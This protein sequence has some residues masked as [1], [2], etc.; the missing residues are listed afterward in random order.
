VETETLEIAGVGIRER[1]GFQIV[2][3]YDKCGKGEKKN[4]EVQ[5]E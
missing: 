1:C 2:G 3:R 4:K 5:A